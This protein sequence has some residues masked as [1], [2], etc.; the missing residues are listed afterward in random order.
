[1]FSVTFNATTVQRY[2]NSQREGGTER[3]GAQSEEFMARMTQRSAL[4]HEQLRG[5]G[6][7]EKKQAAASPSI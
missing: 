6:D 5:L 2:S 7:D 3:S 4:Q 1:M